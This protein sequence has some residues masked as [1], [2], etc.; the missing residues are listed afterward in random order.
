MSFEVAPPRSLYERL[1]RRRPRI[2]ARAGCRATQDTSSLLSLRRDHLGDAPDARVPGVEIVLLVH[3]PIAGFDELPGPDTHAVADRTE[4]PSIPIQLQELTILTAGH[5]RL[6]VRV[7]IQ[8]AHEVSHL[9]RLEQRAVA[10][11][12]DDP[13]FLAI[14]DP[15]VAI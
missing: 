10:G 7:E 5:P 2:Q 12:D 6:A 3:D 4:H 13:V 14:A 11:V 15:D 1:A 9:H 8:R